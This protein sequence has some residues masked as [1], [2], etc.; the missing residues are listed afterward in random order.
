MRGEC[1]ALRWALCWAK[2]IEGARVHIKARHFAAPAAGSCQ[3]R[4]GEGARGRR[5]VVR[6]MRGPAC[7]DVARA[8]GASARP[9]AA[10]N[11]GGDA[12]YCR[13]S[14]QRIRVQAYSIENCRVLV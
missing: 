2:V 9:S 11:L 1:W 3:G 8:R 12:G 4:A 6:G 7:S 13:I 14:P 10:G 5:R